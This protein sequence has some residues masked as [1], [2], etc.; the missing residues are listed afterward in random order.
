[1]MQSGPRPRKFTWHC[2]L[3]LLSL[4]LIF[5]SCKWI[6]IKVLAS[7]AKSNQLDIIMKRQIFDSEAFRNCLRHYD[8]NICVQYASEEEYMSML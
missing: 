4:I 6:Y 2:T 8:N 5:A 3:F 7:R 1:M